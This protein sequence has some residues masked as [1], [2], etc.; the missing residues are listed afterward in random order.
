MNWNE[1]ASGL[2]K[3]WIEN[4]RNLAE[5]LG[6]G[7]RPPLPSADAAGHA[8]YLAESVRQM[9]DL[10]QKS[11]SSWVTLSQLGAAT[12]QGTGFDATSLAKLIDPAAWA[13]AGTG[14]FDVALERLTEG[15]SYATPSDLDRKFANAQKLWNK[16]ARDVTAYQGLVQ[17]AWQKAFERFVKAVNDGSG[18][19]I[20][21]GRDLFDQWIAIANDTL[22]EMHRSPE[23][24]EAQRKMTR[25]S[26]DYRLQEREIAEVFC[27][28]HH[29][30]TRTE[31]DEVQRTVVEL[32]RE[33]R[34]LQRER[35]AAGAVTST[36][37]P[38]Q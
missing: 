3:H 31:M 15:P 11:M 10:W 2:F 1:Q 16:R 8:A 19:P 28:M 34:A 7:K 18:A 29:I 22:L 14:G 9:N 5:A 35:R 17:S 25:S 27:E 26:S 4:Q 6:E 23:F 36:R 33:L 30:P 38:Q 24:L 12:S 21:S 32:R 20:R 37:P 13:K